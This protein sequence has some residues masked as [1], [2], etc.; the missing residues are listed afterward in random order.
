MSGDLVVQRPE[1][2][3][4]PAGDFY[5]DPWRPVARAVITHGHGD[6]A[7][8]G[9]DAYLAHTHSEGLLR[10]RLGDD[11]ALQTLD[12]GEPVDLGGVRVS[13]HPAG[14]ILGSAQVRIEHRG[15][16]WV[17]SGDYKL[18]PDPTCA[19][20]EPVRCHTFITEATFALPIYRWP[21]EAIVMGQINRWWQR[22]RI[23]NRAS[24]LTAYGLGKAQRILA[25]L[26]AGPDAAIGPVFT[27]GSV[28]RLNEAY[29]RSGVRLPA[30]RYVGEVKNKSE[31]AQA[32][33]VAPPSAAGSMWMR[34]FGAYSAA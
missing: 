30:T 15:E 16:V 22:N 14:H 29:R 17:V 23:R 13:L 33:I 34:R 27:H 12:Y 21:D 5:I 3:Y 32:L 20:F 10:R 2:L 4:C 11:I 8:A 26:N 1:G 19:P 24:V 6:H 28:E 31:F 25:S 18:T 9:H 7:R